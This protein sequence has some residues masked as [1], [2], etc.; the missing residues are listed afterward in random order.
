MSGEVGA[1][2]SG[3][4]DFSR[5]EMDISEYD[6]PHIKAIS[7]VDKVRVVNALIGFFQNSAGNDQ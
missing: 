7:L 2:S 4:G 6:L 5:E 1:A 3:L